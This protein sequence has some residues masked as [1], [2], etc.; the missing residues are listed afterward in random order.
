LIPV[1]DDLFIN[2]IDDTVPIQIGL[3]CS[4]RYNGIQ[5]LPHRDGFAQRI[6]ER[7]LLR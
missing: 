6:A 2:D 4:D 3:Q 1:R 5:Y 7:S